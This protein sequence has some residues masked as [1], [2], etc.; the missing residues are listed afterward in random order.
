[1]EFKSG[2]SDSRACDI[3]HHTIYIPQLLF[4]N[5]IKL[6]TAWCSNTLSGS[7]STTKNLL[8]SVFKAVPA[9]T[10]KTCPSHFN[11]WTDFLSPSPTDSSL[12][13]KNQPVT[14]DLAQNHQPCSI[15]P[16]SCAHG[17]ASPTGCLVQER[18]NQNSVRVRDITVN[19]L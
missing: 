6:S 15:P 14:Q 3:K 8:H 17:A 10:F 1:M 19:A 9:L 7:L 18:S 5:Q 13:V 12:P 16:T 4:W 11:H 2:Q